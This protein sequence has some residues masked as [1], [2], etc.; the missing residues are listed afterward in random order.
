M[1]SDFSTDL[2]TQLQSLA[3]QHIVQ[4]LKG[5]ALW[6]VADNGN[7]MLY[8]IATGLLWQGVP[9]RDAK[10]D[11]FCGNE[12]AAASTLGGLSGWR[13]PTTEEL[14]NFAVLDMASVRTRDKS[15]GHAVRGGVWL[16]TSGTWDF[17]VLRLHEGPQHWGALIVVNDSI[18]QPDAE[19]FVR[20]CHARGWSL[21]PANV[22]L[23]VDSL[24][25]INGPSVSTAYRAPA[26]FRG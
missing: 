13:V 25:M 2:Q 24:A 23:N 12:A 22:E 8:H 19:E 15:M 5:H 4:Q 7:V 10:M 11:L 26:G 18:C 6:R 16:T 1:P 21:A 3:V 14:A 9:D 17:D 20:F